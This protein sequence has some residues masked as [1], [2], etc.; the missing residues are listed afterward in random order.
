MRNPAAHEIIS[1]TDE[2]IRQETGRTAKDI[3]ALLKYLV[4]RSGISVKE[5]HWKSYDAMNEQIER[6]LM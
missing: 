6:C 5:E 3:L 1:V 4:V 2:W